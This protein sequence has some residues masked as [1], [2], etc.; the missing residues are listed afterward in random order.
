MIGDLAFQRGEERVFDTMS[1]LGARV[2]IGLHLNDRSFISK[3]ILLQ[4]ADVACDCEQDIVFVDRESRTFKV[5][6]RID[7]TKAGNKVV[8]Y[9]RN[10]LLC[11]TQQPLEFFYQPKTDIFAED[12]ANEFPLPVRDNRSGP[13][14]SAAM[15][16]DYSEEPTIYIHEDKGTMCAALTGSVAV[17]SGLVPIDTPGATGQF[18]VAH[19]DMLY[20]YQCSTATY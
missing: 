11:H 5:F 9:A 12:N 16:E 3:G 8:I 1:S 4:Q 17:K 2:E 19:G 15:A 14:S 13:S 7:T 18:E 10:V 20:Q 6:A